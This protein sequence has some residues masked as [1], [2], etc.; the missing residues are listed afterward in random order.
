MITYGR[1][2]QLLT[3]LQFTSTVQ[4][5]RRIRAYRHRTSRML[6]LLGEKSAA[7]REEEL[8]SLGRHLSENGILKQDAFEAWREAA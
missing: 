6:V 8:L 7:V 2:E 4:P 5:T 3:R 1:L